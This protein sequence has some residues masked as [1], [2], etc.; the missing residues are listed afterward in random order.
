MLRPI[1]VDAEHIIPLTSPFSHQ[2]TTGSWDDHELQLAFASASLIELGSP[3]QI[4]STSLFGSGV[5]S[6]PAAS[7]MLT[8]PELSSSPGEVWKLKITKVGT[9]NRKDDILEGGKKASNRK[10]K[11]WGV[12]LTSSQLLFFRDPT[13][14]NTLRAQSEATSEVV[15]P[16]SIV[17]KPDELLS[18]V[19]TVA[20]YDTSY[21]KV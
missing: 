15:I 16:P 9:L 14:T 21:T 20:V 2:G 3:D 11:A 1:R 8:F 18:L 5:P 4:R 7:G 10:W 6:S 19:D 13:W 12:V 17:F